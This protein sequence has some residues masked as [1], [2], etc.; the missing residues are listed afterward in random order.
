VTAACGSSG[1]HKSNAS[2]DKAADERFDQVWSVVQVGDYGGAL[3]EH[4]TT[5]ASLFRPLT[6]K[7]LTRDIGRLFHLQDIEQPDL[8]LDDARRTLESEEDYRVP[9]QKLVHPIGICFA[10]TW[11]ITEE[12]VYSGYFATGAKGKIIVRASEAAGRPTLPT[13]HDF[14]SFGFAGKIFDEDGGATANFFT[15]DDLGGTQ[16]PSFFTSPKS[17]APDVTLLHRG[18]GLGQDVRIDVSEVLNGP[19]LAKV[20]TTFGIV[21]KNPTVRQLYPVAELGLEEGDTAVTPERMHIVAEPDWADPEHGPIA[22]FRNEL[23][24]ANFANGKL[25]FG[26]FVSDLTAPDAAYTRIGEIVLDQEALSR[27]CDNQ[28]H[29]HHPRWRD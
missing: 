23:H 21:D 8:L 13:D 20:A 24:L 6:L 29:F 1:D 4:K 16:D 15:I 5:L 7:G 11:S 3:P 12:T 2:A 26:I 18:G 28:L 25:T 17:N 22:D 19:T 14:R 27:G 9:F 10:G